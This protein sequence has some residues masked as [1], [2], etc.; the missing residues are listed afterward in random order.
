MV[1]IMVKWEGSSADKKADIVCAIKLTLKAELDDGRIVDVLI[2]F[3][4]PEGMS[5]S[6]A[7]SYVLPDSAE[8]ETSI[9]P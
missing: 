2:P 1:P 6:V 5:L 8:H 4:L 7:R 3:S 9:G